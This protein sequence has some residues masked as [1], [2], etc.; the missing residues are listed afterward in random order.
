MKIETII[1][2]VNV[3]Q[4]ERAQAIAE[5]IDGFI[6]TGNLTGNIDNQLCSHGLSSEVGKYELYDIEDFTQCVND[7]E[8]ELSKDYNF[9]AHITK[10][11][12]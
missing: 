6:S 5:V 9:I 2:L 8:I 1:L 12:Y 4:T 3:I 10:V 11:S 7:G